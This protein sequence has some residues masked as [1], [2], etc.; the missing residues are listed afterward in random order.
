MVI[1]LPSAST[2]RSNSDIA[3]IGGISGS[4]AMMV[5]RCWRGFGKG[6]NSMIK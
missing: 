6:E 4:M 2:A 1:V 3:L 5:A